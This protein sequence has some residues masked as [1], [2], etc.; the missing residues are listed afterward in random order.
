[1]IQGPA[2][3]LQRLATASSDTGGESTGTGITGAADDAAVPFGGCMKPTIADAPARADALRNRAQLAH[4]LGNYGLA[5]ALQ[6][7][8]EMIDHLYSLLVHPEVPK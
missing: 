1:M 6:L 8:A 7:G 5:A 2:L 3:S 4:N